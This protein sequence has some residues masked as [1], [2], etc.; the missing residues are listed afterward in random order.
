MLPTASHVSFP[1][2]LGLPLLFV[3][4]LPLSL[5]LSRLFIFVCTRVS[6]QC[7]RRALLLC[8]GLPACPVPTQLRL[9]LHLL[10]LPYA[11]PFSDPIPPLLCSRLRFVTLLLHRVIFVALEMRLIGSSSGRVYPF[12]VSP[13]VAVSIQL[14]ASVFRCVAPVEPVI[15]IYT[16]TT[17][18]SK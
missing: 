2:P 3:S 17:W 9:R 5:S 7:Q 14:D 8:P 12:S 16:C 18:L 15:L 11:T 13:H 10:C 1:L 4:G 6:F